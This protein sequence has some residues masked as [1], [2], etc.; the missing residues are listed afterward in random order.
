MPRAGEAAR[1]VGIFEK[2]SNEGE[3][4]AVV[5]GLGVGFEPFEFAKALFPRAFGRDDAPHPGPVREVF[6]AL[7]GKGFAKTP[8]LRHRSG[9]FL[10]REGL[11]DGFGRPFGNRNDD[12]RRFFLRIGGQRALVEPEDVEAHR[13]G[14]VDHQIEK[15]AEAAQEQGTP[16]GKLRI[17][18][19]YAVAEVAELRPGAR[20]DPASPENEE[21]VGAEILDDGLVAEHDLHDE[22]ERDEPEARAHPEA[23]TPRLVVLAERLPVVRLQQSPEDG[24]EEKTAEEHPDGVVEGRRDGRFA[25]HDRFGR[26]KGKNRDGYC[27]GWRPNPPLPAKDFCKRR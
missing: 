22:V 25:G 15:P 5:S 7:I 10:G 24:R 8:L 9:L 16:H 2:V 6:F 26:K 12:A 3:G 20:D 13:H 27:S 21:E 11:H 23:R 4:G 14:D 17:V 1:L 19:R 18:G